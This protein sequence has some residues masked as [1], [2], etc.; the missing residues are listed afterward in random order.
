[1]AS[2]G[3]KVNRPKA[4]GAQPA[5]AA[6]HQPGE[7]E[8]VDDSLLARARSLISAGHHRQAV[9]LLTTLLH[10][11][12]SSGSLLALR[13]SSLIALDQRN[14]ALRD[15]QM[16]ISLGDIRGYLRGAQILHSHVR[17][18][19]A[20]GILKQG[21]QLFDPSHRLYACLLK[22]REAIE[23]AQQDSRVW[24]PFHIREKIKGHLFPREKARVV[25]QHALLGAHLSVDAEALHIHGCPSSGS[26]SITATAALKELFLKDLASL[27][28]LHV[29]APG[30]T[31][32]R[33]ENCPSLQYHHRHHQS[34]PSLLHL[35]IDRLTPERHS[36]IAGQGRL[37]TLGV[38]AQSPD[39]V[40][41]GPPRDLA[42][43]KL[44]QALQCIPNLMLT[45]ESLEGKSFS[46]GA[47]W[48]V[49]ALSLRHCF[50]DPPVLARLS[51]LVH[52][53]LKCC[54]LTSEVTTRH[55]LALPPS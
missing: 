36:L 44:N 50:V 42:G 6:L 34:P 3:H 18:E 24:L 13:C 10:R 31:T 33:I 19:A 39:R 46:A 20:L 22:N 25:L 12:P 52:L 17:L 47:A 37:H 49:S 45:G 40:L 14:D 51:R 38:Y 53:E 26:L 15:V 8:N 35:Y 54:A 55:P 5:R 1:M 16:L 43:E 4:P 7:R 9:S 28:H 41:G 32:L 48:N 27:C 30:L 21:L 2:G 29:T 23:R 11:S